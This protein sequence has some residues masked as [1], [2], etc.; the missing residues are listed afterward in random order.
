MTISI[1]GNI[2]SGKTTI[3]RTLIGRPDVFVVEEPVDIWR[4][5]GTLELFYKDPIRMAPTFQ[6]LILFHL[7]DHY[8]RAL[9]NAPF[10]TK[11]I[12]FERSP[13]SAVNIF[14]KMFKNMP[15]RFYQLAENILFECKMDLFIYLSTDPKTCWE[16]TMIRGRRE[17]ANME[18]SYFEEIDRMTCKA[19]A[20]H[21]LLCISSDDD[22]NEIVDTLPKILK[23]FDREDIVVV[24]TE[25]VRVSN[26]FVL[27]DELEIV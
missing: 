25:N 26:Q 1:E 6:L 18:L 8:K 3:L 2:A 14:A 27:L 11:Y 21:S 20:Q 5:F 19:F 4:E 17:E 15:D 23:C 24:T 12:I 22:L 9:E 10:G 16:R 13:F 7:A